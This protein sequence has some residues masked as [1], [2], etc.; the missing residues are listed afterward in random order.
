MIYLDY[1]NR[2]HYNES[3]SQEVTNQR[4]VGIM[5]VERLA[6]VQC[7]EVAYEYE[8]TA[9]DLADAME[10]ETCDEGRDIAIDRYLELYD[11]LNG[12]YGVRASIDDVLGWSTEEIWEKCGDLMEQIQES[13][14]W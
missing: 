7:E 11:R 12:Q 14:G 3:V 4:K 10:E 1:S 2:N 13:R 6:E 5:N 9:Q 8:P